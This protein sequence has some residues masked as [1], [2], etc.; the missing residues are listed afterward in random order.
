MVL[1]GW[2]FHRIIVPLVFGVNG[3]TAAHR[4]SR[5]PS[6]LARPLSL[7]S[8]PFV[9]VARF[10][11]DE[12]RNAV[13]GMLSTRCE[14]NALPRLIPP[15]LSLLRTCRSP[16]VPDSLSGW[17][18][19][20]AACA[21][22]HRLDCALRQMRHNIEQMHTAIAD[23]DGWLDEVGK[24]DANLRG[25]AEPSAKSGADQA[26]E[27]EEEA[28]E[29]EEAKAELR[30]LAAAQEAEERAA[31]LAASAGGE[32]AVRR[33]AQTHAQKYGKWER[34]DVDGVVKSMEEREGDQERLRKE[35][36]RLENQR[37]RAR[38]R[39]AAAAA[40]AASDALKAQ[41]NDAFGK[42]RYEEAVGLYTDALGHTPRAAVL[43]ANRALALLKLGAYPEAEEDCD[44]ALAVDG[45]LVKALLRR[46][47]ARQATSKYD[48]A[49]D[50]LERA[51]ELEPKNAGARSQMAEC[52]R[53]RAD[54]LPPP[55]APLY[56]IEVPEREHDSAHDDDP[57]VLALCPPEAAQPT[58]C[59]AAAADAAG[60]GAGGGAGGAAVSAG[61]T[62]AGAGSGAGS[63]AA[64]AA[65]A[66]AKSVSAQPTA[67]SFSV[68]A[69]LADLERAWRSLR[70]V[71]EEFSALV[72]RIEPSRLQQLF[73]SSLPAEIFT[74]ILQAIESRYF[75]EDATRA[76]ETLRALTKAGHFTIL[77][78]CL[79]RKDETAL[80]SIF[81]QLKTAQEDGLIAASEDLGALRKAYS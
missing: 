12:R 27:E 75:P 23:L 22:A 50:D 19:L 36:L 52:R 79:E 49:L 18:W 70:G 42:A 59:G 11:Q 76:L 63:G 65:V 69:T 61:G 35:V 80:A 51:L 7:S 53:L 24:R 45:T 1:L 40:S 74:A 34:Y 66:K 54:A 60:G 44:A 8:S 26:A 64:A 68:P 58:A 71:P 31:S 28:R 46:A 41:G 4:R 38:E 16:T 21:P 47:Q 2:N 13:S 37:A 20:Y 67:A 10:A 72:H 55:P 6:P 56:R 81:A 32:A 48:G 29:I 73:R 57:F 3:T 77:T 33:D 62:S 5:T 39:K 17:R 30:K 14:P 78:M 25:V 43:Y 15:A 9:A